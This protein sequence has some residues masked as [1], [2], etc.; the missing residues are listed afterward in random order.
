M[1]PARIP[2]DVSRLV[3]ASYLGTCSKARLRRMRR[4]LEDR[5]AAPEGSEPLM[6]QMAVTVLTVAERGAR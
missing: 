3:L 1:L 6:V 4:Y 2:D 5:A